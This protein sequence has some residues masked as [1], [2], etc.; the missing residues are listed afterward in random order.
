ML[1]TTVNNT[2][3]MLPSREN[4][5]NCIIELFELFEPEEIPIYFNN[6]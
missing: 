1:V 6:F 2:L 5:Y 3:K 4:R